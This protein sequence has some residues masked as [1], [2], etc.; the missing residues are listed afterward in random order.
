MEK[1]H[2]EW[3]ELSAEMDTCPVGARENE[4]LARLTEIEKEVGDSVVDTW[5]G[6]F[7]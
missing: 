1:L 5:L 4:L 6:A 2:V 7:K 3:L